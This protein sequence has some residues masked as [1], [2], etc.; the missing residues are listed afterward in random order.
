MVDGKVSKTRGVK[1]IC[2]IETFKISLRAFNNFD[3]KK[4]RE[5]KPRNGSE[6][7]DTIHKYTHIHRRHMSDFVQQQRQRSQVPFE[8]A[9]SSRSCRRRRS[10]QRCRRCRRRDDC[11]KSINP[12]WKKLGERRGEKMWMPYKLECVCVCSAQNNNTATT[13]KRKTSRAS[14]KTSTS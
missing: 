6:P 4:S 1:K 13:T 7:Q 14:T 11:E 3:S 12:N 2:S 9:H 8:A 10:R 5:K